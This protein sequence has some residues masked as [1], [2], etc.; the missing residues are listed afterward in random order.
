MA[1]LGAK[2]SLRDAATGVEA[3]SSPV[4][5][6]ATN[7]GFA[8]ASVSVRYFEVDRSG[9]YRL[10]VTGIDPS[11]DL[12]RIH[13]IFTRPY[14]APLVLLILCMVFGGACLIGGL[15]FTSLLYSGKL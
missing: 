9:P 8:T 10:G 11:S 13:L 12:S 3:R 15:V 14:A 2:F 5:F 6:R 1:M 7:S 4:I